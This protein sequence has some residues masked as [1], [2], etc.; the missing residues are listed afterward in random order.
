MLVPDLDAIVTILDADN[1]IVAHLGDGKG[2]SAK[3][4]SPR[5]QMIPGKFIHP[6]DATF[7]PSGDILVAEWVPIG[8]ITLLRK[9]A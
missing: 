5:D 4:N 8:R 7:L 6:H 9:L 3:R 1:K 2:S